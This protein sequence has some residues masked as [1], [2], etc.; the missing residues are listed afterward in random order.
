VPPPSFK[1]DDPERD[2]KW[3]ELSERL[4]RMYLQSGKP[5]AKKAKQ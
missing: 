1:P 3:R 5:A 4:K 2:K